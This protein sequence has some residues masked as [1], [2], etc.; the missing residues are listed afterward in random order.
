MNAVEEYMNEELVSAPHS[1]TFP[2]NPAMLRTARDVLHR[3]GKD[4]F[5]STVPAAM[6]DMPWLI[7]LVR[8]TTKDMERDTRIS[9]ALRPKQARYKDSLG[10]ILRLDDRSARDVARRFA[11][12][13]FLPKDHDLGLSPHVHIIEERVGDL[14]DCILF[15]YKHKIKPERIENMVKRTIKLLK[16]EPNWYF[17]TETFPVDGSSFHFGL[18]G[19]INRVVLDV[20][21]S[22]L[23]RKAEEKSRESRAAENESNSHDDDVEDDTSRSCY[24]NHTATAATCP[25]S[26]ASKPKDNPALDSASEYAAQTRP[27][28][29]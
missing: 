27:I 16:L 12:S 13:F 2:G 3:A 21:L 11:P 20:I 25:P 29:M 4:G 17:V 23:V 9:A 6:Q 19:A 22:P 10:V 7:E 24:E 8:S 28:I 14:E 5:W 15:T 1:R 26:I 18:N